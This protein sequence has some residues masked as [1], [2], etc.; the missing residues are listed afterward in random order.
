ME[1]YEALLD[2]AIANLPDME[3][4]DARFVIPE[5]KIMVEGKTTILDNFNNIADVLNREPDHL[6]KYLTR[7]MG[8]AGKIDG[9]R[10]VFQGRFS[11]D[12]IQSN[13]E[14]YVEEFVMCSECGRPDTQLTKMDRILVLKCAACGAHRP[15]KKRRASAPVKQ[16]SIEE[17]KEYDV[18]IDA[19]GSKGDGIA[20]VD[21][22]TI[23]VP[24]AAKGE[25]LKI[26]IKRISGTLAF[27]EKA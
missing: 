13:I 25:T 19:V 2:R 3:T 20:K 18:R 17:G 1:D 6:M 21:K 9:L 27:A 12:Q 5:P 8:T 15:V 14:A 24:G 26:R 7:E 23:F 11:K 10:A 22:F 16:D 4:T